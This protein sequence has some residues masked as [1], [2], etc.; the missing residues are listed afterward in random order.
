MWENFV[1]QIDTP[2]VEETE[3][4]TNYTKIIVTE[5]GQELDFYAQ[6]VDSGKIF[7]FIVTVSSKD[8]PWNNLPEHVR[9]IDTY[10]RFRT[11]L[12]THLFNTSYMS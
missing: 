3:R 4:K 8:Y 10:K 11:S 9:N 6:S 1:E 12:K 7:L 2:V 5:V